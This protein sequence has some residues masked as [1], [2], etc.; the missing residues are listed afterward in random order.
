MPPK[1]NRSTEAYFSGQ[2]SLPMV[3]SMVYTLRTENRAKSCS[4]SLSGMRIQARFVENNILCN[5]S[6]DEETHE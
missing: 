1:S 4:C 3:M 5:V 6:F 2:V